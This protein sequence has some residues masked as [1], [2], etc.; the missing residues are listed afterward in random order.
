MISLTNSLV[1]I[2]DLR[3]D[4]IMN[5]S[6][7]LYEFIAKDVVKAFYLGMYIKL[8]FPIL[9]RKQQYLHSKTLRHNTDDL[10][11][12]LDQI[13]FWTHEYSKNK[14]DEIDAIDLSEYILNNIIW[15]KDTEEEDMVKI[16]LFL[17]VTAGA[18]VKED[19]T[20]LYNLH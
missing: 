18:E 19:V 16:A 9:D 10:D 7:K 17:G 3:D 20:E 2:M 6:K 13:K 5:D 15:R 1:Y 11:E 8:W 12:Y 14:E 4:F